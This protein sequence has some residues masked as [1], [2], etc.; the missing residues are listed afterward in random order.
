MPAPGH[1][2]TSGN[3]QCNAPTAATRGPQLHIAAAALFRF[4]GIV[5][6]RDHGARHTRSRS[7]NLHPYEAWYREDG[8]HPGLNFSGRAA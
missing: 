7:Y 1:R 4:L 3:H 5:P 6:N 2:P 8:F